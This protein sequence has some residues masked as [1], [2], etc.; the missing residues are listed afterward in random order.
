MAN[1]IRKCIVVSGAPNDCCDYLKKNIRDNDYIIAADSGYTRL[2]TTGI[3]PNVIVGDFDSSNQPE[4]DC[5][6]IKLPCEKA[7]CDTLECVM[8]AIER[9]FSDITILNAIGNRMDH[10]YANMLI[11]N[12]CREKGAICRICDEHNRLSLITEKTEIYKDYNNFSLFAYLEDCKGVTIKG[13]HYTAGFYNLEKLDIKQGDM[14]AVS[15]FVDS[16]KCEVD[17]ESGTLL[18]IESND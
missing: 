9:G 11:L 2:I 3:I 5:E 14:F 10:T 13:A 12:Y 8:L 18:L 7:Y 1:E 4:I 16:D 17:L 15:N 6:I